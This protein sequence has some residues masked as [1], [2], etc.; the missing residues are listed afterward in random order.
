MYY[1]Y[2]KTIKE[3][4][5]SN[6]KDKFPAGYPVYIDNIQS[7]DDNSCVLITIENETVDYLNLMYPRVEQRTIN[8]SVVLYVKTNK[9]LSD[10]ID[11]YSY[12]IEK[13]LFGTRE[14]MTLGG[15]VNRMDLDSVLQ[16]ED[17]AEEN[18]RVVQW[19]LSIIYQMS[20]ND[21][22]KLLE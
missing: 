19:R 18:F 21:P 9:D 17:E 5:K 4:L 3:K 11:N 10:K 12:H 14:A 15:V 2:W 7:V 16:G 22:S 8:T 1:H 20:E 13:A 6:I